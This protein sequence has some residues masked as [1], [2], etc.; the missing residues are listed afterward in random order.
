MSA[1]ETTLQECRV[2][3]DL[4]RIDD[5]AESV[6]RFGDRYLRRIFTDHEL[7]CCSGEPPVA[8]A[9]LAARFAAKEA[10]LKMLQPT[11]ARP[12]WHC[13]EVRRDS[14]GS[15]HMELHGAAAQLAADSGIRHLSISLTHEGPWAAA[16]VMA[17]CDDNLPSAPN[18]SATD[19]L[20]GAASAFL[21]EVSCNG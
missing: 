14:N 21:N 17:V 9:G 18:L 15:C 11:G 19:R 12:E 13:T 20:P 3:I 7:D 8:A 10:A 2:G 6:A 16:V 1:P 5:V 4:V